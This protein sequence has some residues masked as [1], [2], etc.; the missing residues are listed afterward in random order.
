MVLVM[1][2]GDLIVDE[3]KLTLDLCQFRVSIAFNVELHVLEPLLNLANS[4]VVL[5]YIVSQAGRIVSY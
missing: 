2:V 5:V 4:L 3:G 1:P